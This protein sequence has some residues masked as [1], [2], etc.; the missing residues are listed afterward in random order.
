MSRLAS[1]VDDRSYFVGDTAVWRAYQPT[2]KDFSGQA[3]W[4]TSP[5][6]CNF[7]YYDCYGVVHG[8]YPVTLQT[9]SPL[10]LATGMQTVPNVLGA[11]RGYFT[12][13]DGTYTKTWPEGG[14]SFMISLPGL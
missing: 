12:L 9:S 13:S 5:V 2:K 10:V 3:P 8:P 4:P 7:Y 14:I 6:G 1:V 11:C